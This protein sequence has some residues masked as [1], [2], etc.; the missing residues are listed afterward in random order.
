MMRTLKLC[1]L[2]MCLHMGV[3]TSYSQVPAYVP[4]DNL[5][6]WYAF[7]GN[8]EDATSNAFHG[9]AIDVTTTSDRAGNSGEA[10]FFNGAGS[11]IVVPFNAAFNAFPF[12]VSLWCK[13]AEDDNGGVLIQRYTNASWNG[14]IMSVGS[15][16][17]TSQSI[18]PGYMLEA[19]PNCNG[20]VSSAQCATGIDYSG[21]V[22]DQ[23]WH[24]LT[25]TVDGDSGRF[26]FDGSLQTTQVWT[27]LAGAPNGA[28]DL[29]IGGTDMGVPFFFHGALD[30]VGIWNRA[31]SNSEV[32]AMFNGLPPV[33]GCT[34]SNACNY[35]PEA[36]V[37]DGSCVLDCNGCIDP[38]ACNYNENAAFDDG[39]CDY[40]C[41]VGMS[42]ITVFHDEN[43]NGLFDN[44]ERPMHYWPVRIT[45]LQKV[46]YTNEDGMI[47]M[48]LAAGIVHYELLS[49]D[50]EWI[51]TTPVEAEVIVPGST[52]AFFGLRHATGLPAVEA[53]ELVG[54]YDYM[55][56]ENGMES[57]M[58]VRNTGGQ[59]LHGTLTFTCDDQYFP[60][61]AMSISVPPNIS[62]PGFAQWEI[63]DL[64]PW[65]TRLLAFH[66][67]GPGVASEGQ[68]FS[69]TLDIELRNITEELVYES[70][71]ASTKDILCTEPSSQLVTNPVGFNEA[72]HYVPDG[73]E[74]IFRV[75]FQ[76][77]TSDWVDDFMVIQNLNS[78]Q[79]DLSSFELVYA[80]ESLVGCLHD[81]GTIDLQFSDLTSSP[82][83]VDPQQL[84]GY[85]I[86]RVSL[87][88]G[89]TPDSTFYHT[90][91][92]VL[93]LDSTLS[94]DTIYHTI[95]D[96]NR[97]AQV[98][99][100]QMYCEGDT[101][102]LRSDD[103]WIDQYRW[104]LNDS[105]VSDQP[106]LFMLFD[107][108]FYNVVS[109]FTN[110]VCTVCLH[111][112]IT[113]SEAP[114]ATLA[115]SDDQLQSIGDYDCQW[116]FNNEPIPGE[117]NSILNIESDGI[118][119]V[120][121]TSSMGCEAWSE[122]ILINH[123]WENAR[124]TQLY[125][126]P[127]H[128]WVRMELPVGLYHVHVFDVSGRSVLDTNEFNSASRLDVSQLTGGVYRVLAVSNNG[129]FGA[130]LY[131]N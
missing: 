37:N 15:T 25:F 128:G 122:E 3:T 35:A 131:I 8:A 97:L 126:N 88:P 24:M 95:Y 57:G 5:L 23:M 125:P 108:G 27:G 50:A 38:C 19:P 4:S 80:S 81:D 130:S 16:E 111:N 93:E 41:N 105:L 86:Y 54:Y 13:L 42:F 114:N 127:S 29:R 104:F 84:G 96:C 123:V 103:V 119:Q 68:S 92:V 77:N 109:E 58:Y 48:P 85:A 49:A 28:S 102:V 67:A 73:S 124:A 100:D 65:E 44:D 12:T 62:G 6:A 22:Y 117:T 94:S 78:Q 7:T 90:M 107:P 121:W 46:V 75:Q 63:N 39:S 51:P 55:Q 33:A 36:T 120:L 45:E 83:P 110:P 64:Q 56:C 112:P 18:S 98:V 43:N 20:V 71:V 69:Y 52:Q 72:F 32:N 91:H 118:Y 99:G 74:L 60:T 61:I 89:I 53:E 70:S 87:N 31:L 101:V 14:W 11:E 116:Y 17:G 9:S 113:I 26:Y 76:N 30:D 59:V 106:E 1:F 10:Y 115:V 21:D 40:S 82:A 2:L 47:L 34:N 129:S 66:V 79:F